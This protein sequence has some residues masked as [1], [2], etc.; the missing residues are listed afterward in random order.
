LAASIVR[1]VDR[2][3]IRGARLRLEARVADER[4]AAFGPVAEA[5][6]FAGEVEPPED[7]FFSGRHDFSCDSPMP[8][9]AAECGRIHGQF[10]RCGEGW[11]QRPVVLMLHGWNGEN[12]YRLLFPLLARKFRPL[13]ISLLSFELPC[14]GR[15]RARRAPGNDFISPDLSAMASATHQAL[16]DA[17]ALIGWLR[18]EGCGLIGIWGISLGAWLAGLLACNDDRLSW[19][20]LMT[21]IVRMDRAIG[22][23]EFCAPIRRSLAGREIPFRDL[24]LT[25]HRPLLDRRNLLLVEGRHDLFAPPA[26]VEELW[27]AWDHPPIERFDHGHISMMFSVKAMMRAV[28]F[29]EARA[30][31]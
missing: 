22:E 12:C 7:L 21:P 1:S 4:P 3:V 9:I 30:K 20:V 25:M 31:G 6:F 11:R 26:G 5:D 19:A 18:R 27:Q 24:N 29:V 10:H 2:A 15:R 23:L 28:R 14:H 8:G 16:A 13:G 17:R